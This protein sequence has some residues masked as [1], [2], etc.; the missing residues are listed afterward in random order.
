MENVRVQSAAI[1]LLQDG[2]VV[3]ISHT[4][5]GRGPGDDG[6][7]LFGQHGLQVIGPNVDGTV[8]Q[9]ELEAVPHLFRGDGVAGGDV[10]FQRGA[11]PVKKRCHRHP[12]AW[13]FRFIHD[14]RNAFHLESNAIVNGNR[15]DLG[16]HVLHILHADVG[17]L[18]CC[19]Q[20]H[21]GAGVQADHRGH[22]HPAFEDKFVPVG[23][24]RNAFQKPLHHIVA[25]QNLRVRSVFL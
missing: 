1:E 8:L 14:F 3:K 10:D 17:P 21:R 2:D 4:G 13:I 23:R 11:Y 16:H 24:E 7:Q 18:N 22:Q 20:V 25:H 9:H 6:F 19:V 15:D 12:D 5:V